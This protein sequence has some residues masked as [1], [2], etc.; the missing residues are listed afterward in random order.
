MQRPDQAHLRRVR[1]ARVPRELVEEAREYVYWRIV[2][3]DQPPK[4]V[5]GTNTGWRD[6]DGEI[7]QHGDTHFDY[8]LAACKRL[9]SM[10]TA[11]AA[12]LELKNEL[13]ELRETRERRAS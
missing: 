11:K 13:R 12:L 8:Y 10:R 1:A 5:T 6:S 7:I 2:S 9:D 4:R 3:L